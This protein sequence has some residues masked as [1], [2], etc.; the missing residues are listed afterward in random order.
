MSFPSFILSSSLSLTNLNSGIK[1]RVHDVHLLRPSSRS[2][3]LLCVPFPSLPA[4]L[5]SP[6]TYYNISMDLSSGPRSIGRVSPPIP[7][8]GTVTLGEIQLQLRHAA[9][10]S[11]PAF[12]LYFEAGVSE[13]EMFPPWANLQ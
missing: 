11:D 6:Y 4:L 10:S 1:K 3:A 13:L 2:L 5:S 7:P 9:N 8:K 12:R